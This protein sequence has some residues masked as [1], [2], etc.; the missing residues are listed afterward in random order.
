EHSK[1]LIIQALQLLFHCK[2]LILIEYTECVIPIVFVI[3][4]PS[5]IYAPGGTDSWQNGAVGNIPLFAVLEIGS[6]MVLKVLDQRKFEFSPLFQL[7]YVP[8]R[9]PV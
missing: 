9:N 7:A 1:K 8:H 6:F 2:Y 3:Y 4:N 5:V